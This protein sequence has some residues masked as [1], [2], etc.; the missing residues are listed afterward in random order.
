MLLLFRVQSFWIWIYN[1]FVPF[2]VNVFRDS[3]KEVEL[4]IFKVNTC[5]SMKNK[6]QIITNISPFSKL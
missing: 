2:S 4:Y 3:E 1:I 6:L 5:I